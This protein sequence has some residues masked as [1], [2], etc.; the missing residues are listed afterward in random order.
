MTFVKV[1][2]D[3]EVQEM[4]KGKGMSWKNF[5]SVCEP[6]PVVVKSYPGDTERE[7]IRQLNALGNEAF[8]NNKQGNKMKY[9]PWSLIDETKG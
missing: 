7:S 9:F 6:L 4:S 5:N 2:I 1:S 8:F 3:F